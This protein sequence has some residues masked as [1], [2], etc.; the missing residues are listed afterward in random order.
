MPD[1][2]SVVE[3]PAVVESPVLRAVLE[4]LRQSVG[5]A[6][7]LVHVSLVRAEAGV[8]KVGAV[9]GTVVVQ[10]QTAVDFEDARIDQVRLVG[11]GMSTV[12]NQTV[13]IKDAATA[14]V[15]A[16]A[17]LPLTTA[18]AINGSWTML[19]STLSGSRR[20]TLE[21]VGNA[22]ATQTLYALDLQGRTQRIVRE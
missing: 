3:L 16:T 20:L 11:W 19:P 5:L 10:S 7:S 6:S 15:L 21:V 14:A 1:R 12:A 4:E 13:R 9:A 18:A 22:A 2:V 17:T 8:A